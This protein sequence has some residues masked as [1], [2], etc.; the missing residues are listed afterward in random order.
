VNELRTSERVE[1]G[2]VPFSAC[3]ENEKCDVWSEKAEGV[4]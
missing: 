1:R 4:C 2:R 3:G